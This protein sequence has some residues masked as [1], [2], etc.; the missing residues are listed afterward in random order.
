MIRLVV[1]DDQALI[2]S[3]LRSI[4]D[5][6]HDLEVVAEAGNGSEAVAATQR[7]SPDLVLMDIRMPGTDGIA[8]TREILSEPEPPKVLVL[9]TFDLD[10]YIHACLRAGASG[11]LLKD[12]DPAGIVAAVRA[13]YAGDAVLSAAV[14]RRVIA[15]YIHTP[16]PGTTLPALT[17][18]ETDVLRA[19]ARGLSNAEVAHE[20]FLGETTVKTHVTSILAKLGVRDRL[21][22]V[23]RAYESG[24]IR[25][26]PNN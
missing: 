3:S 8:A 7:T 19:V 2:R 23:I 15:S 20:L 16:A 1:A 21:Q 11:F 24:L 12:T 18:R 25:P 6:E 26:H 22:A 13:T 17:D 10:E 4:F 14:T 5:R 9:T